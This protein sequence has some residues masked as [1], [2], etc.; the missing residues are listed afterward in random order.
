MYDPYKSVTDSAQ[1]LALLKSGNERYVQ[2]NLSAKGDYAAE[3]AALAA[4]QHPFAI[5]LTCSDS[6]T[7]PEIFFDQKLGDIFV[8]RIAGNIA[9]PAGLGSIEYAAEHLKAPLVAVVGHKKCGAVT[10]AY[11]NADAHGNL[12]SVLDRIKPVCASAKDEDEAVHLNVRRTVEQIKDNEVV[13]QNKVAV[14]GAYYDIE[15]GLV[16]WL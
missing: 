10:A 14:V 4:G 6:R 9:E 12:K 2:N 13:K 15:S 5:V 3:R 7:A 11:Q 16:S 1:A 8:V